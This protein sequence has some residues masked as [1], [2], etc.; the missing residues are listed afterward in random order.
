MSS[1][2]ILRMSE[3]RTGILLPYICDCS[4]HWSS[5]STDP[6]VAGRDTIDRYCPVCRT[7]VTPSV[8]SDIE[9]VKEF[10]KNLH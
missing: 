5:L 10:K 9:K 6:N 4:Y 8:P 3:E 1:D 7:L 2:R